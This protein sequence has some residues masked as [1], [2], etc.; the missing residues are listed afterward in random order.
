MPN[1][2]QLISKNTKQPHS[3]QEIDNEMRVHFGQPPD[4]E[5]WLEG[6]Y[7]S[8]GFALAMGRDFQWCRENLTFTLPIVNYLEERFTSNAWVEHK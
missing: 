7:T 2:F 8:I 3:L 1:C 5:R 4:D 6:W